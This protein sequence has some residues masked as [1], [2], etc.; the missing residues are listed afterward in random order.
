MFASR[1]HGKV[2]THDMTASFSCSSCS[3]QWSSSKCIL[4]L[5]K[6]PATDTYHAAACKQYCRQCGSVGHF[7]YVV[8]A[9]LDRIIDRL[10]SGG[11]RK[12]RLVGGRKA[13]H[14]HC[15]ACTLGY[16]RVG[17][18]G[19]VTVDGECTVKVSTMAKSEREDRLKHGEE[20]WL[21]HQT[22][23]RAAESILQT[24]RMKRGS[25]L[26]RCW[27]LLCGLAQGH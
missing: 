10:T 21:F 13:R 9:E 27:H 16:H 4:L 14:D 25:R 20:K 19:V 23:E 22:D 3:N 5:A 2:R 6:P 26:P 11:S 12:Q 15:D 17:I 1:K 8:R 18:R 7:S 24:Q